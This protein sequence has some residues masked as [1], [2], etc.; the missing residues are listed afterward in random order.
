MNQITY[1]VSGKWAHEYFLFGPLGW[2]ATQLGPVAET[3][4]VL[5]RRLATIDVPTMH[6]LGLALAHMRRGT[7]HESCAFLLGQSQKKILTELF[8]EPPA[9]I[10]RALKHLPAQALAQQT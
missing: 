1:P 5:L 4:P 10:G 7:T 8:G 6:L 3:D 2:I 9:G